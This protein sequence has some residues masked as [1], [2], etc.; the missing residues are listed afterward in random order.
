[1]DTGRFEVIV[2]AGHL[3]FDEQPEVIATVKGALLG[4]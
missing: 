3:L 4:E 2:G 1:L